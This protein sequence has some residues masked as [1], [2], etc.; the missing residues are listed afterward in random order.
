VK[1]AWLIAL[2][3]GLLPASGQDT[4]TMDDIIQS[5]QEWATN[6]LDEDTVRALQETD[7]KQVKEFLAL[8]QKDF[9]GEYVVDLAQLRGAAKIILPILE[10]H[11]ETQPYAIWLKARL[12]YLDTAEELHLA[13]PPPKIEPGQPAPP[14]PNPQPQQVREIWI[15]E[16]SQQPLPKETNPLVAELK[17]IFAAEKIPPQLVWLAEVES[18]FDAR[19]RSPV[20]AA[21]LFQLM[22]ATAKRFGLRTWPLDQRLDSKDSARAA[23]KY[24]NRLHAQFKDWRLAV[25][26]YNSGEG[27]VQKLLD[28]RKAKTYDAIATRLPA[29][30]QMYVPKVEAVLLRRE[31][32]KLNELPSS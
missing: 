7:Q 1:R 17:P 25:A 21:G 28:K 3:L 27:T 29:E 31:G 24:L 14:I 8:I 18:S 19:A 5:A 13:I 15:K 20:G 4:L 9:Q 2:L 10:G 26:A 22:P 23:A 11:E 12:D 32:V 6:N 30:T 16:I